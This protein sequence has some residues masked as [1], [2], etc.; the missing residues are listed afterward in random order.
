[1]LCPLTTIC[2]L[3]RSKGEFPDSLK[4]SKTVPVFKKGGVSEEMSSYRPISIVNLFSKILESIVAKRLMNFLCSRKFFFNGQYGFLEGRSTAQAVLDLV[5]YI[6]VAINNG[7]Y[8]VGVFLDVKKA[9]DT[10][11]HK[12]LLKK[13]ENAGVR[14]VALRWF[15]NF[16][17]NRCQRVKVDTEWSSS[18]KYINISVLQGSI[19]GAI[20]FLIFINDFPNSNCGK[21]VIYADDT[22]SL[23]KDSN[24]EQLR[25]KAEFELNKISQWFRANKL[26]ISPGKSKF[27]LFIP[28]HSKHIENFNLRLFNNDP[29]E[30]SPLNYSPLIRVSENSGET[31]ETKSIRVLGVFLDERLCFKNHIDIVSKKVSK[32]L[33]MLS[34]IKN[35]LPKRCL[36]LLYF[37]L[38]H[39][40]LNYCSIILSAAK[41]SMLN[42]LFKLQKKAVRIISLAEFRAHT[43][44]LFS[45]QNILPLEA[46]IEFNVLNFMYCYTKNNLSSSLSNVFPRNMHVRDHYNLRNNYEFQVPRV[47]YEC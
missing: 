15:E 41:K 25:E 32:S 37:S 2:N 24:L 29:G 34:R 33:F 35:I 47:R 16:L 14:G 31:P 6:S 36:R 17:K 10:V 19:L 18:T 5:N 23:F 3:S 21:T 22:N 39:S 4:I 20:L 40:H 43:A 12:I 27:M 11:N 42:K 46:L 1:V 9:F 44:P 38:I 7:E 26:Q 28:R 8:C 30:I 45:L 13:L